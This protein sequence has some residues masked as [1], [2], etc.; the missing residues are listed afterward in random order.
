MSQGENLSIARATLTIAQA[1]VRSEIASAAAD[2]K[3]CFR[4]ATARAAET[5]G[6]IERPNAFGGEPSGSIQLIGSEVRRSIAIVQDA[7]IRV[8][9]KR[10]GVQSLAMLARNVSEYYQDD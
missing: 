6:A 5:E 8:E 2:A 4:G 7:T 3:A 1:F 9:I 10:N